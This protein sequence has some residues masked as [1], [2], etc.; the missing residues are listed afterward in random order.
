VNHTRRSPLTSIGAVVLGA[1]GLLWIAVYNGF[2]LV[3]PDS[4]RY[5]NE[6]VNHT[7]VAI[8][9]HFYAYFVRTIARNDMWAVVAIQAVAASAVVL[10]TLR[11]PFA[12]GLP[13][14]LAILLLLAG[15]STLPVYT[16]LLMTDIWI[17][18]AVVSA[19][20]LYW[21]EATT[22]TEVV[23]GF[24]LM[25]LG[26]LFHQVTGPLLL[27]VLAILAGHWGFSRLRGTEGSGG[28]RLVVAALAVATGVFILCANNWRV[29]SVFTPS[30]QGP[31]VTFALLL[32]GGVME[33]EI[34]RVCPDGRLLVC[35]AQHL[36]Y[37]PGAFGRF[38]ARDG[39]LETELGGWRNFRDEAG[40][41]VVTSILHHPRAYARM[42]WHAAML[43]LR[44]YR[45][46]GH[47][48]QGY[49][50]GAAGR[51]VL[52]RVGQG[53]ALRAG[54]QATRAFDLRRYDVLTAITS[55]LSAAVILFT[56]GWSWLSS[57]RRLPPAAAGAGIDLLGAYLAQA[58][59]IGAIT[60]P[61]HRYAAR[62][63]W[64]LPLA[65]LGLIAAILAPRSRSDQGNTAQT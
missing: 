26:V 37:G 48:Q 33:A 9:S 11:R 13:G 64:I 59:L 39:A 31:V 2:P 15:T 19:V 58:I 17:A 24:C 5:L 20:N 6:A 22:R 25:V 18:L 27:A 60:A 12:V 21:G 35:S 62:L 14:S 29:W 46:D 23:F 40:R 53:H 51:R 56:I 34:E 3:F 45:S 57:N 54:K 52:D 1:A 7:H 65:A 36:P 55:L 38:L 42:A 44:L 4:F 16:G 61:A 28:A 41:L 43:Q 50:R 30:P 47:F 32:R 8:S 63:S 10:W 49:R